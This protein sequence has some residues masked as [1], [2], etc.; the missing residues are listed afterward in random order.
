MTTELNALQNCIVLRHSFV[1][2]F[3]ISANAT[4]SAQQQ[5]AVRYHPTAAVLRI[6]HVDY[7]MGGM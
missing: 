3:R 6:T 4:A 7:L 5:V 2:L 1:R